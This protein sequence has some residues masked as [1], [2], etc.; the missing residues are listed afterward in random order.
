MQSYC[1]IPILQLSIALTLF[2]VSPMS[3][4]EQQVAWRAPHT[5]TH[6]CTIST[7]FYFSYGSSKA[8]ARFWVFKITRSTN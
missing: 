4:T 7:H 5:E 8:D 3:N 2:F 1:F 6:P